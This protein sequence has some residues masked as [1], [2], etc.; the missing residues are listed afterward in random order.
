MKLKNVII[1]YYKLIEYDIA[2]H[3]TQTSG[4]DT[5]NRLLRPLLDIRLSKEVYDLHSIILHNM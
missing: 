5:N 3:Y 4:H 1:K 2:L